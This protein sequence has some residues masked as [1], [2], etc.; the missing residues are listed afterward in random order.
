M[1]SVMKNYASFLMMLALS[2]CATTP[3]LYNWGTYPQQTYLMYVSPDKA[4]ATMQIAKLEQ[5]I[6]TTKSQGQAVPPGLYGHLG[7]LY[8]QTQNMPKAEHYFE[9]EKSTYPESSV[10]MD[11]LLKKKTTST[12]SASL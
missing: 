5:E 2:G 1:I 3:S 6:E 7:L 12:E 10:L 4:T 11:R 9:F 8:L